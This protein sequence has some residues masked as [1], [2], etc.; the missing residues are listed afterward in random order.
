MKFS[1]TDADTGAA[2]IYVQRLAQRH[3]TIQIRYIVDD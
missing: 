1:E 3:S 2:E